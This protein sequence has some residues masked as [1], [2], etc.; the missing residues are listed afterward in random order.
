MLNTFARTHLPNGL[1][2][3]YM[4][5]IVLS[6]PMTAIEDAM[7]ALTP[8]L[9]SMGLRLNASKSKLYKPP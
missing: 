4:D 5:D 6:G 8:Q 9:A 7:A 2:M 1:A 3:A